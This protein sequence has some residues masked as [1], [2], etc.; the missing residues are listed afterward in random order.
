M[1]LFDA[2]DRARRKA[3]K[4]VQQPRID[5]IVECMV[6]AHAFTNEH[7]IM[8]N[9]DLFLEHFFNELHHVHAGFAFKAGDRSHMTDQLMS[10]IDSHRTPILRDLMKQ[11]NTKT[12]V[13]DWT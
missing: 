10:F 5:S 6:E 3:Y 2:D 1:K 7:Y 8:I 12:D 11:L 4:A 9:R 13:W